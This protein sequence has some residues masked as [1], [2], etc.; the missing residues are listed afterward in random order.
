MDARRPGKGPAKPTDYPWVTDAMG[1]PRDRRFYER[2]KLLVKYNHFGF[3][4]AEKRTRA[5]GQTQSEV[6]QKAV[7]MVDVWQEPEPQPRAKR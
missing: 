7:R 3:Y 5:R 2:D 6:W 1:G 4:D